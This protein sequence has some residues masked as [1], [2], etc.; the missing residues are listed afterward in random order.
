MLEARSIDDEDN[1]SK[2]ANV[3]KKATKQP[4]MTIPSDAC[5]LN[6]RLLP[7]EQR[8]K[9]CYWFPISTAMLTKL[10][11]TN[12]QLLEA[13]LHL[14]KLK[15]LLANNNQQQIVMASNGH[16]AP[17][18]RQ[19]RDVEVSVQLL[20]LWPLKIICKLSAKLCRFDLFRLITS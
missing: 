20:S 12:E 3:M 17:D 8:S 18:N 6:E 10:N 4:Q 19:T 7:I 2:A 9:L 15:P 11:E 16:L 13:E 5:N 14:Y 1:P